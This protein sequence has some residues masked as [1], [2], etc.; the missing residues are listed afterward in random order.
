MKKV[1]LTVLT[2]A[3]GCVAYV[4]CQAVDTVLAQEKKGD[5]VWGSG[6]ATTESRP[7]AKFTAIDVDDADVEIDRTG[8]ESLSVTGDDNMLQFFTSEVKKGT[9]YL[10][11]RTEGNKAYVFKSRSFYRVTVAELREIRVQQGNL[12][13][14]HL[15][16]PALS[17]SFKGVGAIRLAGRTDELTLSME[18]GNLDACEL[19]ARRAKVV[20][21]KM[22]AGIVIV[23]ASDT[24]DVG[25]NVGH[26]GQSATLRPKSFCLLL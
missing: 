5:V 10:R 17:V 13:A 7:V 23:N 19:Q 16:G 18:R 24:L 9:L 15:D 14:D 26:H 2:A 3:I 6:R 4:G 21:S 25:A 12:R 8:A 22:G 20:A 1:F 11:K